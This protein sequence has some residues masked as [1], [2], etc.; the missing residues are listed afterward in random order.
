MGPVEAELRSRAE[1]GALRTNGANWCGLDPWLVLVGAEASLGF[2][3][4]VSYAARTEEARVRLE[5]LW[6]D[7]YSEAIEAAEALNL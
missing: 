3:G 2:E 6:P 4:P 1:S 5:A 7:I